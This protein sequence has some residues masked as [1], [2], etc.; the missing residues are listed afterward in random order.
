MTDR[1]NPAALAVG[2]DRV[3]VKSGSG[4]TVSSHT[5]GLNVSSTIPMFSLRKQRAIAAVPPSSSS[6]SM[7]NSIS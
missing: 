2:P 4:R 1:S 5:V 3:R 7:P 6:N